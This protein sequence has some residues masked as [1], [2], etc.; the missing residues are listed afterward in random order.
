MPREADFP[1][2]GFNPAPG[3]LDAL[4]G[5]LTTVGRVVRES[6]SAQTELG[7]L[8]G[9]DS[10]WAGKSATAFTA[11]VSEIPPYLRNALG[12]L[13]AAQRAL[14]TWERDLVRF[15]E[16]ARR[17]ENEA[18]DAARRVSSAQSGMDGLPK[19]TEGMSGGEKDDHE[20]DKR[21]K[22]AALDSA[23]DELD[24]VRRRARGLNAEFVSAGNETARRVKDAA[25]NAPPEPGFFASLGEDL[26]DGFKNFC[27]ENANLLKLVGDICADIAM[28]V[29]VVC[30]AILICTGAG[31]PLA[32]GIIGTIAAAGALGGHAMAMYG[33]HPGVTWQTLGW[34]AAGLLC[35]GI[36]LRAAKLVKA[37]GKF[38]DAGTDIVARG[39][40]MIDAGR[41]LRSS[42]GLFA[43]IKGGNWGLSSLRAGLGN[44]LS[45]ISQG[46]KGQNIVSEGMRV[47]GE[48]QRLVSRGNF[49]DR[50]GLFGGLTLAGG[51][52][53]A[54]GL[55]FADVPI[56][57]PISDFRA[58]QAGN[59]AGT[60]PT[61][62]P[63]AALTS[64]GATFTGG[65]DRSQ[66]G[67]AA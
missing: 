61:F 1:T 31:A 37:G 8:G 52:K 29:G 12:S 4:R 42:A 56:V 6:E 39:E 66:M 67:P 22:Q 54:D 20:K 30:I 23:T 7:K 14:Q 5:L 26:L 49:L 57:G 48:G 27:E 25:G 9:K 43:K 64:A 58:A 62:N 36:G 60:A 45:G 21:S 19:D 65:L 24:D 59:T 50:S 17:L 53:A 3:N 40:Q 35:G 41:S 16:R 46:L 44:S 18:A 11:S 47:I 34:D 32:L 55:S 13:A 15:Q 38:V 28:I 2:L 63:P 51:S 33:G 10:I